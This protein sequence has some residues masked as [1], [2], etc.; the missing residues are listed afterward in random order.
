MSLI[1]FIAK[2]YFAGQYK[3]LQI[4][5]SNVINVQQQTLQ[6][7]L[8]KGKNTEYGRLHRL[9]TASNYKQFSE[10]VPVVEHEQ[11]Y[12]Y[13]KRML[14][15]EQNILWPEI[16]KFSRSSGTTTGRS[17]YIPVSDFDLVHS[18]IQSGKY[19]HG[20]YL[21][22]HTDSV[23]FSGKGIILT[24]SYYT[25]DFGGNAQIADVSALLYKYTDSWIN[26][27]KALPLETALMDDWT[28]KLDAIAETAIPQNVT[29]ISGVATWELLV[30][31]KTLEKTGAAT[32]AEVWPNLEMVVHG[33]VD[34]APYRN[35]FDAL[36]GKKVYYRNVYNASEGFF[37]FQAND[38]DDMLLSVANNTFYEF[39]DDNGKIVPLDNVICGVK[40]KMIITN[41][42]GLWRY[43]IGDVVEFVS[44]SPH[45]IKLTGRDKQ[46]INAVGEELIL[47]N[48]NKALSEVCSKFNVDFFDYT[49]APK[50]LL[51][52]S[53]AQHEWAIEFIREPEDLSAFAAALDN[54][55]REINSD[56]DAKRT[57]DLGLK[58]LKIY[59]L[60]K[61]AFYNWLS[62]KN[63]L[64]IQAKI[65]RLNNDGIMLE[66]VLNVSE[67][68]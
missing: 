25:N 63:R 31:Q 66:E 65:P 2:A 23:F 4:A 33:G 48:T 17:K 21:H 47:E 32:I 49:V 43:K 16:K 56:Y 6:S 29:S 7:I 50:F 68:Q 13:I 26:Y 12:P 60:K 58:Q 19:T 67:A 24:G 62:S 18:H 44:L 55:L 27:F 8:Q 22:Q 39:E 5:L 28:K 42:S 46:F 52:S 1:D 15:G 54:K 3:K 51:G 53:V 37:A 20:A 64:G 59:S 61:G 14:A 34:F 38:D 30:L 40:Y 11:L 45:K 36:I 35:Q 10:Q 57:G 9:N 41:H